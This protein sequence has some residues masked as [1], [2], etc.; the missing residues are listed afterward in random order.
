MRVRMMQVA[1]QL[2]S[3]PPSQPA[4]DDAVDVHDPPMAP[5][6][7][8]DVHPAAH[9]SA[10]SHAATLPLRVVHIPR[11]DAIQEARSALPIT[12]MEQELMEAV[13]A[14]DV[15][16][17]AGATGCGKTT[18]VPQFLLE[19]GYGCPEFPER[20]G[21]VGVTQ[22]RRVA[23]VATAARVAEEL[24]AAGKGWVGHQVRYQARVSAATR[25]KFMTDG[26]LLRELQGDFLLERYSCVLVDE[27]HERSLNTDLLIGG[28]RLVNPGCLIIVT[29]LT[30]SC[31][32]Q[33]ACCHAC[34]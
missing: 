7:A 19:A 15:L 3:T 25:V 30:T 28:C 8:S 16:V 31:S 2:R 18:Q 22:P 1:R 33:P 20:A 5:S 21:M 4:A 32:Q 27:A 23:A 34:Y 14:H 9:E 24:G 6:P 11:D 17:L 26:I 10:P 29:C 13:N 12:G